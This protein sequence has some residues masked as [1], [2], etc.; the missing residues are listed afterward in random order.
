M[1]ARSPGTQ[2]LLALLGVAILIVGACGGGAATQSPAGSTA[3]GSTEAA[4]QAPAEGT[5][6][7]VAIASSPSATALREMGAAFTAETG[8]KVEFVEIPYSDVT[9]KVLLAANQGSGGYDIIQFDSPWLAPLVAGGALAALD[10]FVKS[11]AYDITDIP[12]QVREYA[13][14]KGTQYGL[15][16]STEPYVLWYR[17]DKLTEAGLSVPTNWDEYYAAAKALT[18]NGH[19]GSDSGYGAEIGG[20]YFLEH[21]YLTGG[22]L[23]DESTCKATL[24]T[25]AARAAAQMYADLIPFTPA[26]ALNGGG[27]EMTTSF[28]QGDASQMINATGYF[29]IV[30][31]PEQSKVVGNFDMAVPPRASEEAR[32]L[33]FG[34]LIGIGEK[35]LQ[36]DAAWQFLEYALGKA[37]AGK[38][39]ELGAPPVA[40]N[41][42]VYDAATLKALPYLPTLVDA[43]AV[44]THLPYLPAMSQIIS[45]LSVELNKLGT[46]QQSVDDFL[47]SSTE[48][49]NQTLSEAGGCQ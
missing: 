34:W 46:G 8:I 5:T 13:T 43:A 48:L 2:R 11:E 41:S 29:S 38:M 35:S 39:I 28:A 4:S 49:V 30:N 44:G 6:L 7:K 19:Y 22:T 21:L 40:R 26:A 25:D 20:Y 14:Y 42:L 15:P 9:T 17:T 36:K 37:N 3:P 12:D 16:F 32:T 33:I 1:Q 47:A 27:N 23:L 24:D 10:D 31:D 18:A 45:K